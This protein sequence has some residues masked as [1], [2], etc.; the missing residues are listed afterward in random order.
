M[1]GVHL[2]QGTLAPDTEIDGAAGQLFSS[3]SPSAR[4]EGVRTAVVRR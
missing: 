3:P 2:R 4:V 1:S